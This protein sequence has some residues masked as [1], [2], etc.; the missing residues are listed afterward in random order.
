MPRYKAAKAGTMQIHRI[1]C[2]ADYLTTTWPNEIRETPLGSLRTV[3]EW[4]QKRAEKHGAGDW[5]KSWAWQGYV[6]YNVGPVSV[7]QRP[8]GTILRLSGV[9]AHDWLSDGLPTGH[10][11]SRYDISL[12]IWSDYDVTEV[13][14]R[15][16]NETVQHRNTLHSRP[17]A[18]TSID[19][20]GDGDTLYIGSRSSTQYVR[21]Y[22]KGRQKK[23]EQQWNKSIRYECEFKEQ[24]AGTALDRCRDGGYGTVGCANVLLG[25]L[26]RRGVE[27]IGMSNASGVVLAPDARD[28]STIETKLKWLRDQVRPSVRQLLDLGMV[29]EVID[30]LGIFDKMG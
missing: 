29:E 19:G 25:S 20:C 16:K 28:R 26:V 14:A 9:S 12:T 27:P 13:I 7:G 6:G 23:D 17:Y 21:I 11:V 24:A 5:V 3:T 1:E 15:H 4:A 2:G 8:D 30:A 10:N 22:D 18:V